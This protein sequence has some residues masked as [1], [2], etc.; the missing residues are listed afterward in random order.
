MSKPPGFILYPR[1]WLLSPSIRAMTDQ[2]VRVYLELLCLSWLEEPIATLP[3]DSNALA[4][5]LRLSLDEWEAIK[6]PIMAKFKVDENDRLYNEKLRAEAQKCE[7]KI[8]AG[9]AG[10][11]ELR[12]KRAAKAASKLRSA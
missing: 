8:R 3:N 6:T 9:K 2:Q 5:L 10:W 4:W 11:S 7:S 1:D 12:R